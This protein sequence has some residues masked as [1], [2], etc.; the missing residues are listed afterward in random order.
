MMT[1]LDWVRQ[2]WVLQ[3]CHVVHHTTKCP[4]IRLV[5]IWLSA[6]KFGAC[7][8]WR[9][10]LALM[11]LLRFVVYMSRDTQISNLQRIKLN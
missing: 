3:T 4:H 5:V 1:F 2:K 6:D 8:E 11:K 10:Y 9:S 7:V